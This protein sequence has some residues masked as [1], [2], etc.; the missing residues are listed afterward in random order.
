MTLVSFLKEN[1]WSHLLTCWI[2]LDCRL[3]RHTWSG[4][5]S[6]P[7][8]LG[9]KWKHLQWDFAQVVLLWQKHHPKHTQ[10]ASS[11]NPDLS[12]TIAQ[13]LVHKHSY[14]VCCQTT[15]HLK[16]MMTS[17]LCLKK[18]FRIMQQTLT[19][20]FHLQ[21]TEKHHH[22][23]L[24]LAAHDD[25]TTELRNDLQ[26]FPTDRDNEFTWSVAAWKIFSSN[27]QAILSSS[28]TPS[29]PAAGMWRCKVS[30]LANRKRKQ[31][32]TQCLNF[33]DTKKNNQCRT[34]TKE[35]NRALRAVKERTRHNGM[36]KINSCLDLL[37]LLLHKHQIC[38]SNLSLASFGH[39][40]NCKWNRSQFGLNLKDCVFCFFETF[41]SS[42]D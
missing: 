15:F 26:C 16:L 41:A 31:H 39:C 34:C 22:H 7:I 13:S 23:L 17:V 21:I 38:I 8:C 18:L 37:L 6:I 32:R 11:V 10:S 1:S 27:R 20:T 35:K 25:P 19:K 4:L 42:F 29:C 2:W 12:H 3:T 5:K 24:S 30:I 9:F 28:S 40:S 36:Q 33:L 14:S